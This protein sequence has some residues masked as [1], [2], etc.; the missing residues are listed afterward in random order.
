MISG[1]RANAVDQ[2]GFWAKEKEYSVDGT[3]H[4]HPG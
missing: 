2:S 3:S 4:A 1:W